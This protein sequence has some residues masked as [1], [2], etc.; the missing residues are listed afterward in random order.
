L[1]AN[2]QKLLTPLSS[3][4]KGNRL[5]VKLV[6]KNRMAAVNRIVFNNKHCFVSGQ[7][8]WVDCKTYV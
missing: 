7:L 6:H 1:M 8:E 2:H 4:W 3:S 5:S